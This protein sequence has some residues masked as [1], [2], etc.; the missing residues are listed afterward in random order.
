MENDRQGEELVP[1]DVNLVCM[2]PAEFRVPTEDV[3]LLE[4][5]AERV[6]SEKPENLGAYKKPLFIWGHLDEMPIRHMLIDGGASVNILPLLLIKM[7]SHI[8]GDLTRTNL[9][10]SGFAGELMEAK[11]IICKELTAGSKT[12]PRTFF[13]V[14]VKGCYNMLLG[15]DWIHANKCVPSTPHQCVIQ[16]VGDEVKVV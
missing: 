11:G 14:D 16:W 5:G 3:A 8:E 15:R 4:L 10:L 9:R 6:M 13:M 12:V 2:I 7:L 1:M